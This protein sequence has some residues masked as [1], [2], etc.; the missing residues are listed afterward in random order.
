MSNRKPIFYS[1][2]HESKKLTDLSPRLAFKKHESLL[3]SGPI[4]QASAQLR[5]RKPEA[6]A[7]RL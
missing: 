5:K 3:P 4:C 2:K 1:N 7:P 6:K